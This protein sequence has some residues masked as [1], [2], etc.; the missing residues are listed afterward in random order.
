[1]H[2]DKRRAYVRISDGRTCGR[3]GVRAGIRACRRATREAAEDV[4]K[5]SNPQVRDMQPISCDSHNA[6]T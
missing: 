3:Q 5:T 2:A 6:A 1:M 4:A